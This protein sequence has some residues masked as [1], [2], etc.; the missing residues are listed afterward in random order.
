MAIFRRCPSCQ[1]LFQG[2][3][4]RSCANKSSK[5]RQKNNEALKLYG[6]AAWRKC[7][8]N[9]R[10]RYHDLDIWMLGIGVV[11]R[12]EKTRVH[13]ILERDERPD[14]LF[15]I[16]NLITVSCDSHAEIHEWYN[17]SAKDKQTAIKRI[18][19]GIRKFRE[20]YGDG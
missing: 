14:L 4:C 11:E 7:R 15:D 18:N 1:Q 17:K 12:C 3:V 5:K 19:A 6:G 10:I 20:M 9:V 13:H 8:K 2:R 16:D